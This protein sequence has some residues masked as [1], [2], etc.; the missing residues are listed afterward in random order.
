MTQADTILMMDDPEEIQPSGSPDTGRTIIDPAVANEQ[1]AAPAPPPPFT[2]VAKQAE[3]AVKEGAKVVATNSPQPA[4]INTPQT[5]TPQKDN[6]KKKILI[7]GAIGAVAGA[8][9]TVA[10]TAM[11]AGLSRE[12][13]NVDLLEE[14]DL[15]GGSTGLFSEGLSGTAIED[16]NLS[17]S[18]AFG[19]ARRSLGTT[20]VFKWRGKLYGTMLK[21]EWDNLSNEDRQQFTHHAQSVDLDN[22]DVAETE[23]ETPVEAETTPETPSES[24]EEENDT[25]VTTPNPDYEVMEEGEPIEDDEIIEGEPVDD[26]EIIEGEPVDDDEIIEGEPIEDDEIIEGEPIEDDEIIEGEPVDD[27]EIEEEDVIETENPDD[28]MEDDNYD[29]YENDEDPSDFM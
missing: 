23:P 22:D 27:D 28:D 2:E 7:A 5:S 11:A 1:T 8:A 6:S 17:F 4:A 29:D 25:T 15:D 12:E 24:I 3:K 13:D 20:G 21:D 19:N 14:G 16:D 9:F 26:D 18:E 10:G